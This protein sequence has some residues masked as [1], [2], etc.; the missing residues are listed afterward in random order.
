VSLLVL[1]FALLEVVFGLLLVRGELLFRLGVAGDLR[2][3]LLA[4]VLEILVGLLL[5]RAELF[6]ARRARRCE[7]VLGGTGGLQLVEVRRAGLGE[8]V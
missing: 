8:L 3:Y 1:A 2:V 7:C 5:F 6:A 4:A